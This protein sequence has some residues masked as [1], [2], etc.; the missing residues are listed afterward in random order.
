MI[1]FPQC[2]TI[3]GHPTKGSTRAVVTPATVETYLDEHFPSH[4]KLFTDGSVKQAVL[5]AT[6]TFTGWS[7]VVN[8]GRDYSGYRVLDVS[9]EHPVPTPLSSS[10]IHGGPYQQK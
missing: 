7:G 9:V 3:P 10:V 5:S 4:I 2:L 8:S 1:F 6:A